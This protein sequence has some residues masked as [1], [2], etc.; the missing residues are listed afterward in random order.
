[1]KQRRVTLETLDRKLNKIMAQIDDLNTALSGI[2]SDV[3][4]VAT[5]H[6]NLLTE[7]STAQAAATAG[8]PVDLTAAIAQATAIKTSLD[9]I[10]STAAA[11]APAPAAGAAPATGA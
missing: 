3:A 10:A 9:A 8:Q 4:Q 7:L 2:A 1:M 11:A 6:A 5:D